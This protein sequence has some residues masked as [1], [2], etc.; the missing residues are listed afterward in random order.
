LAGETEES[1]LK[2]LVKNA[3]HC[4][5]HGTTNPV[6]TQYQGFTGDAIDKYINTNYNPNTQGVTLTLNS[7][8]LGFY[9]RLDVA[10]GTV[11]LG[12]RSGTNY[13][14]SYAK[15]STNNFVV[16]VNAALGTTDANIPSSGF[17]IGSRTASNVTYGYK[18]TLKGAI[19]TQ[20]TSSIPSLN[21]YILARNYADTPDGFSNNE[22]ACA[23]FGKGLTDNEVYVVNAAFEAYMAVNGKG[24][25]VPTD[26]T[27][28]DVFMIA[29]QSNAS[30]RG[31][32][33]QSFVKTN[34]YDA[35]TLSNN[36]RYE[37]LIDPVDRID[38]QVDSVSMEGIAVGGSIW[39]LIATALSANSKKTVF[40]PCAKGGTSITE[41]LPGADHEDRDTLYGSMVYR[42]KQVQTAGGTLRAVLMWQGETDVVAGMS[43]ATYNGHIDTFANAIDT[44]LSIKVMQCKLHDLAPLADEATINAAIAEAWGDNANMLTGPDLNAIQQDSSY[45]I[46]GD[47]KLAQVAALWVTAINTAFGW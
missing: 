24:I 1:S 36:Y 31:T 3:H 25:V 2:N 5:L 6:F 13:L 18:N 30:G 35:I 42:A 11:E 44:D 38:G 27:G 7:A 8:S 15:S 46:T 32:N 43:Q 47:A 33:Y 10:A 40:I 20:G 39:P 12:S 37:L 19:S 45:H 34:G 26:F 4:T 23:F 14:V 17:Y 22:I 28:Y 21:Q 9:N 29:G 41:W 16:R